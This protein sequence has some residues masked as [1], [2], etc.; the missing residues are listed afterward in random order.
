MRLNSN[1]TKG[2]LLGMMTVALT[3]CT[4]NT[5]DNTTMVNTTTA[6][7]VAKAETTTESIT[8]TTT[9]TATEIITGT[10]TEAVSANDELT[11]E[12][13]A[14]KSFYFSSGIGGW[15]E[16][17]V[18]ESDGTIDGAF[19]DSDMGDFR[20]EYENGTLYFSTYKGHFTDLKRVDEYSYEMTLSDIT[21]DNEVDTKEIIDGVR[22]IYTDSYCLGGNTKFK[23]YLK[24]TPLEMISDEVKSWLYM[25]RKQSDKLDD[26]VIVDE[27][28]GYGMLAYP[29]DNGMNA[30]A[31]S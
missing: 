2:I 9:E 22:Y 4:D 11:F 21:Y 28:N 18:I 25:M 29:K 7:E 30:M 17:F 13:F 27:E 16:E 19:H 31:E 24:G 23:V 12:V 14:E 15:G 20:P 5:L 8:E 3:G 10:T 6:T 26:I 1:I